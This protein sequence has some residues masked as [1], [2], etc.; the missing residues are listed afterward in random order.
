MTRIK[1]ANGYPVIR[2]NDADQKKRQIRII[3]SA[4]EDRY[5]VI[6]EDLML[7]TANAITYI[8]TTEEIKEKYGHEPLKILPG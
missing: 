6:E 3:P 2:I 4:W 8:A 1:V 5:H 7:S